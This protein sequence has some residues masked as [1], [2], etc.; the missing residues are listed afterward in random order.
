MRPL[1]RVGPVEKGVSMAATAAYLLMIIRNAKG[2]TLPDLFTKI[3]DTFKDSIDDRNKYHGLM[4]FEYINY[5]YHQSDLLNLCE[6]RLIDLRRGGVNGESI[7][8]EDVKHD[9]FLRSFWEDQNNYAAVTATFTRI[10]NVLNLKLT[11]IIEASCKPSMRV[12]PVFS[13]VTKKTE[14]GAFVLMPFSPSMLPIYQDHIKKVVESIGMICTRSDG[15]IGPGEVMKGV[16]SS[17]LSNE[18]IIADLTGRNANVFYELG[19][20]HTVGKPTILIAQNEHD[21]PFDIHTFRCFKYEYTPRGMNELEGKLARALLAA[22]G[23][24]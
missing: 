5:E 20:A 24:G 1:G 19:L 7:P 14:R 8:Y 23:D 16:W 4:T 15:L 11:D 17:I 21:I 22:I 10:Q 13:A 3:S 18:V 2:I 9:I 12:Q 6:C